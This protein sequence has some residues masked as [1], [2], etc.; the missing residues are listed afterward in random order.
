MVKPVTI[1]LLP[2]D[3]SQDSDKILKSLVLKSLRLL[4][5][6]CPTEQID[7]EPAT[8][9]AK[10]IANAPGWRDQTTK[11][12][13]KRRRV[14]GAIATRISQPGNYV[15]FHFDGDTTWSNR[16]NSKECQQ[17]ETK[18]RQTIEIIL[19]T[20]PQKRTAKREPSAP[21]DPQ[22]V[23][24]NLARLLPM[25]PFYC[26][27]SWLYQNTR[28]AIK[29]CGHAKYKESER[30]KARQQFEAWAKDRGAL[31]EL[32]KPKD[33]VCLWS[34]HNQD[35][36]SNNFPAKEVYGVGTSFKEFVDS[37]WVVASHLKEQQ[38]LNQKREE[39]SIL[40]GLRQF[41]PTQLPTTKTTEEIE[42]WITLLDTPEEFTEEE[43]LARFQGT[44]SK[45]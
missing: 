3:T 14:L 20:P 6:T 10:E 22:G 31:D 28:E 25:V 15:V 9:E 45:D 32:E 5:S 37:L 1:L 34:D 13:E 16:A 26:I 43:A 18:V 38:G 40:W 23:A 41:A 42:R 19:A 17:F 27:E 21:R 33:A 11:N 39:L 12:A 24:R 2:E 29:I 44:T 4:D 35:L 7:F 8:D 30:Q 36:A